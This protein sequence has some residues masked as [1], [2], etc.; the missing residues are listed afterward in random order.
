MK[1]SVS[2]QACADPLHRVQPG[3]KIV[4]AGPLAISVADRWQRSDKTERLI[5]SLG[6]ESIGTVASARHPVTLP[7]PLLLIT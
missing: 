7:S 5:I 6:R 2:S 3:S 1:K 4:E